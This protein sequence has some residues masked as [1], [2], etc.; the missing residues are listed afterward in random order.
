VH[1]S[2]VGYDIVEVTG[3]YCVL[4]IR[5]SS[6]LLLTHFDILSSL[7]LIFQHCYTR[8]FG[9]S[10]HV[11]S[12]T[13]TTGDCSISPHRAPLLDN[14]DQDALMFWKPDQDVAFLLC[15]CQFTEQEALQQPDSTDKYATQPDTKL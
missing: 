15:M 12:M 9:N 7:F 5:E 8:H 14:A 4:D 1:C 3:F 2:I 11:S 13:R 10:T 6:G